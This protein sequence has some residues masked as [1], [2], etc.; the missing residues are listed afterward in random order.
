MFQDNE[1][2][3][4]VLLLSAVGGAADR[5]YT[6]TIRCCCLGPPGAVHQRQQQWGGTSA[7]LHGLLSTCSQTRT[8][9]SENKRCWAAGCSTSFAGTAQQCG[10][11][12]CHKCHASSLSDGTAFL[13]WAFVSS[14]VHSLVQWLS[15]WLSCA[16]FKRR[17]GLSFNPVYR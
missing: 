6:S 16:Q 3:R 4:S 11:T 9:A 13:M 8:V 15:A 7:R 1:S 2:V 12:K 14:V 17:S 10:H 5:S